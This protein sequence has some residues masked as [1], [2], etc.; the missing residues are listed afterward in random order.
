M[1]IYPEFL[2]KPF[3]GYTCTRTLSFT[4]LS[5]SLSHTHTHAHTHPDETNCL[6]LK[7]TPSLQDP[8]EVCD[9]HVPIFTCTRE[10]IEN[11]SWDLTI[12][13]VRVPCRLLRC[14][15][16]VCVRQMCLHLTLVM[17]IVS[18]YTRAGAISTASMVR[19]WSYWFSRGLTPKKGHCWDST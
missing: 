18:C 12:E 7:I 16:N 19:P 8:P 4:S 14:L 15:S 6:H 13:Q 11:T 9:Y 2:T 5:L 17:S 10:D 1:I 3:E